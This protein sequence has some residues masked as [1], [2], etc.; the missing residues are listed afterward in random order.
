M[1]WIMQ[2]VNKFLL[3]FREIQGDVGGLIMD[4][5]PSNQALSN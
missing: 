1:P 2:Y 3:V 4:E 5:A